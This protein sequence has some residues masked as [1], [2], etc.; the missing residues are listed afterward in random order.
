MRA[1]HRGHLE[2]ARLLLEAGA[3]KDCWDHRGTTALMRACDGGNLKV[4]LLLL[5]AG[6]AKDCW[7]DRAVTALMRACDGGNLKVALLL[8]EAGAA[9]DCWDD[10]AVTALMRACDGGHLKVARL[11]LEAG[12]AKDCR[13][14]RGMTAL[15]RACSGGHFEVAC[16]LLEA[17]AY[18]NYWDNDGMTALCHLEVALEAGSDEVCRDCDGMTALMWASKNSQL[19]VLQVVVGSLLATLPMLSPKGRHLVE[20]LGHQKFPE[21]NGK[22]GKVLDQAAT[23][24]HYRVE[25]DGGSRTI[26][27]KKE[28]MQKAGSS[29]DTM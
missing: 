16:L 12:A 23:E 4:A 15:M 9:K 18:I 13:D 25:I 20:H 8:L 29:V 2:V 7:D 19:E 24:G 1:C 11:L 3:A 28:N 26:N 14:D 6:A 21:H 22:H 17:C 10:R 27:V 5:E